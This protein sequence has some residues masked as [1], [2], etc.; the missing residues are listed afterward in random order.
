MET[1]C[2]N[3]GRRQNFRPTKTDKTEY[4]FNI[5]GAALK[6]QQWQCFLAQILKSADFDKKEL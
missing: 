2:F 6:Y 4:F 5:K 3:I 1:K